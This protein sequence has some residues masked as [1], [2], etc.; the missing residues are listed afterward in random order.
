MVARSS[1]HEVPSPALELRLLE[2]LAAQR[3][4]PAPVGRR[5]PVAWLAAA[6]SILIVGGVSYGVW[7]GSEV[8]EVR[9]KPDTTTGPKPGA[10][11]VVTPKTAVNSL[12]AGL[13]I[14]DFV[15]LPGAVG[16]PTFESG[17]IV[18]VDLPVSS[19]PAYGMELVPDAA[20]TEVQADVLVGQDGQA[21][22][23]RLVTTSSA[24]GGVRP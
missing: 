8:R 21:R 18:R 15:A 23:I 6:A 1:A 24:R 4:E 16:L 20:H 19:L 17:R 2:T 9:P 22:A 7:R 5:R 11:R 10:P 13:R 14:E 12:R 3:A